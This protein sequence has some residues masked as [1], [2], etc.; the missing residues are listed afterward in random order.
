MR[1]SFEG[2]GFEAMHSMDVIKDTQV[3]NSMRPPRPGKPHGLHKRAQ[4]GMLN[5][6]GVVL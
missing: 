4:R 5:G 2:M 1:K 6:L 3:T